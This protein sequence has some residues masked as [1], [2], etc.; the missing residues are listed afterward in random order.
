MKVKILPNLSHMI[1]SNYFI[2]ISNI[3]S[4]GKVGGKPLYLGEKSEIMQIGQNPFCLYGTAQKYLGT[5]SFQT[6]RLEALLPWFHKGLEWEP[7][8]AIASQSHM[9]GAGTQRWSRLSKVC[10]FIFNRKV[11]LSASLEMF[12]GT[13][14]FYIWLSFL[15]VCVNQTIDR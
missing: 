14:G 12:V 7:L 2:C 10:F 8:A 4:F 15:R 11:I 13:S 3:F 1:R 5:A 6:W 9:G